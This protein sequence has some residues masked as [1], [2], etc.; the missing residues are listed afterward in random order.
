MTNIFKNVLMHII[1]AQVASDL[2]KG[3]EFP[4]YT[5]LKKYGFY[6]GLYYKD[7]YNQK[8]KELARALG[9][10]DSHPRMGI[11]YYVV[12]K[13]DQNGNSSNIIYFTFKIDGRRFQM[14][15]HNFSRTIRFCYAE[16]RKGLQCHWERGNGGCRAEAVELIKILKGGK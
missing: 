12:R 5:R 3:V 9:L 1:N 4:E 14:S 2:A 6:N 13:S 11:N 10:I 7:C 15:F 8:D 16:P